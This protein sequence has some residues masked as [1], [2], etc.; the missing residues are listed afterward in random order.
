[1]SPCNAE[2]TEPLAGTD[3]Q[4]Q[5]RCWWLLLLHPP[6]PQHP[7]LAAALYPL[8]NQQAQPKPSG[9]LGLSP[10]TS[11]RDRLAAGKRRRSP[12][13]PARL[14]TYH[15]AP[16]QFGLHTQGP[17][18]PQHQAIDLRKLHQVSHL[19]Y[20][21]YTLIH[22][23]RTQRTLTIMTFREGGEKKKKR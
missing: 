13:M 20:R 19:K 18:P 3:E 23:N 11:Q 15:S 12:G 22:S 6:A 16:L 5:Q 17:V 2:P 4:G 1:M 10:L 8:C 21:K 9:A 14:G 7:S